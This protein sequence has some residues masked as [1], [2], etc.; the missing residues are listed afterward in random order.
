MGDKA[1]ENAK[2]LYLDLSKTEQE[3]ES[4]EQ[5]RDYWKRLAQSY[6]AQLTALRRV[7]ATTWEIQGP[8]KAGDYYATPVDGSTQP[9]KVEP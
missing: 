9:Q 3:W 6:G 1:D 7:L 4:V 5:E 2:P 8:D